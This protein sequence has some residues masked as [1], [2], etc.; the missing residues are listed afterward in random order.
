MDTMMDQALNDHR[1]AMLLT[2]LPLAVGRQR[3]CTPRRVQTKGAQDKGKGKGS[4]KVKTKGKNDKNKA[5]WSAPL[6]KELLPNGVAETE[7]KEALCF[8]FNCKKGCMNAEVG[9]A[10]D[11]GWHLCCWKGCEGLHPYH[12]HKHAR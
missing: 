10:C 3:S 11:K 6:P 12:E 4:G 9:Q 7:A 2:P 1:F 5:A 8:G